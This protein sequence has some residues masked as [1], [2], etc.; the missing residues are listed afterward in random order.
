VVPNTVQIYEKIH[1]RTDLPFECKLLAGLQT[2]INVGGE[3]KEFNEAGIAIDQPGQPQQ[4]WFKSTSVRE[5]QI[6]ANLHSQIA[7]SGI[8]CP[9]LRQAEPLQ[10]KPRRESGSLDLN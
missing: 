2:I 5:P 4:V 6:I 8:N 9:A 3:V 7:K 1:P 10:Q